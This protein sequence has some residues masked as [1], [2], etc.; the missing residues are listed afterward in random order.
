MPESVGHLAQLI[1][2]VYNGFH[3]PALQQLSQD[4]QVCLIYLCHKKRDLLTA[5]QCR[6]AYFND[7]TEWPKQ[8]TAFWS[9][10]NNESS[11]R[12]EYASGFRP[13]FIAGEIENQVVA[14]I[15][16]S[17]VLACVVNNV[18]GTE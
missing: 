18:I 9:S 10:D 17:V 6:K 2:A 12:I 7:V 13:R 11:L 14:P 8:S 3:F 15:A 5:T 1:A 16:S 4:H